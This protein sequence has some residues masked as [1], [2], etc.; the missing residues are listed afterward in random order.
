[1]Q[2]QLAL[3]TRACFSARGAACPWRPGSHLGEQLGLLSHELCVGANA[4][5]PKLGQ[6]RD[7]QRDAAAAA[8]LRVDGFASAFGAKLLGLAAVDHAAQ[9]RRARVGVLAWDC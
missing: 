6:A 9:E 7:L 4:L 3:I 5:V 8:T 2:G 1:M